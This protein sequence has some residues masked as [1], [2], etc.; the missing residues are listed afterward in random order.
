MVLASHAAC[1]MLQMGFNAIQLTS[2][3]VPV[4]LACYYWGKEIQF[5]LS[6]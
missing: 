5:Y 3:A 4:M 6:F 2:V 1:V